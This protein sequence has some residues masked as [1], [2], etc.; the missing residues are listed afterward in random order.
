MEDSISSMLFVCVVRNL[1]LNFM[2]LLFLRT[3]RFQIVYQ[4]SENCNQYND[5]NNFCYKARRIAV[6]KGCHTNQK[7]CNA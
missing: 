3:L 5:I 1:S 2:Q 4:P 7:K 6:Y